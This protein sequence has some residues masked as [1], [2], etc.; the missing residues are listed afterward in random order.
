MQK[1][2]G[3]GD[4]DRNHLWVKTKVIEEKN[5]LDNFLLMNIEIN[6]CKL[7]HY[8]NICIVHEW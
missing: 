3:T 2:G 4:C 8:W 6:D 7:E 5:S 1:K